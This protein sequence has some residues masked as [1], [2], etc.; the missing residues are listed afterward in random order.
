MKSIGDANAGR[1]G[2]RLNRR[3]R[4][5]TPAE[6]ANERDGVLE[7]MAAGDLNVTETTRQL[8]Q[9]ELL[10]RARKAER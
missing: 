9:A 5:A 4:D 8:A 10:D 7:S 3:R 2:G 6:I 1:P